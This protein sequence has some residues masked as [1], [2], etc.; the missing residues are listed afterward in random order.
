MP[1]RAA[2]SWKIIDNFMD[3][4]LTFGVQSAEDVENEIG[5]TK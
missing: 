4:L 2:R 1:R 3:I 5:Q